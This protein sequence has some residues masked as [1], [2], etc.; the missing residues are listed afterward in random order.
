MMRKCPE[1][2][3]IEIE[4]IDETVCPWVIDEYD[5]FYVPAFFVA[6]KKVYEGGADCK[7][8]TAI[9]RC[10]CNCCG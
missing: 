5:Y 8:I 3:Q 2:S 10:A 1:F 7:D 6:G 9:L 4:V